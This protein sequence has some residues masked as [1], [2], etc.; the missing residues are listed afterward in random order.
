LVDADL[1]DPDEAVVV[2][3]VPQSTQGSSAARGDVQVLSFGFACWILDNYRG[4]IGRVAPRVRERLV[5]R[6]IFE[7]GA[8]EV[9]A[10]LALSRAR[11]QRDKSHGIRAF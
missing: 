1:V 4:G 9:A 2:A 5:L 8:D 11:Q 7:V 3:L 6:G 10:E